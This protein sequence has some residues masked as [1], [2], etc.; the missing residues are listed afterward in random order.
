MNPMITVT[1]DSDTKKFYSGTAK[2]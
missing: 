1:Y 2:G